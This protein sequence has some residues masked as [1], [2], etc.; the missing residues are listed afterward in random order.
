[1][2]RAR[3][4]ATTAGLLGLVLV[5]AAGWVWPRPHFAT[6]GRHPVGTTTLTWT[7]TSRPEITSQDP[8]RRRT[9]VAQAWYPA[10][11][12]ASGPRARYFADPAFAE[13]IARLFGVPNWLLAGVSAAETPAVVGAAPAVGRHPIIVA[14]TGLSGS[15]SLSS[16]Q[17]LELASHGY[18]VVALDQ[19]GASAAVTLPDGHV[20]PVLG[21]KPTFDPLLYHG[22]EPR[23]PA[24]V[25][26]GHP[27]PTGIATYL[28]DDVSSTLDHLADLADLATEPTGLGPHLD[29]ERVGVTGVSLGGT[30]VAEA[31]ARDHR[32]RA[33]LI[34]EAPLTQAA[35]TRGLPQPV[36]VITRGANAMRRE[37][38]SAGGWTEHEIDVH[39]QTQR[40]VIDQAPGEA[41]FVRIDTLSHIDFTDLPAWTPLFRLAGWSGPL[42]GRRGHQIINGLSLTFFDHTL[43]GAGTAPEAA[44][45]AW[46]EAT[47]EPRSAG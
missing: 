40:A 20:A 33:T 31:S 32:I 22:I 15:R 3:V 28:A 46:P 8:A 36:M 38:D 24:P 44:A 45:G 39:Q 47:I 1:M 10:V 11:P 41:W 6:T 25:V 29:L 12:G 18:V 14:C 37:R 7:D 30:T 5:A 35:T 27:L 19:P 9:L 4:I 16:F 17:A 13:A 34:L 23:T 26:N 21:L 43:R 42:D 2:P